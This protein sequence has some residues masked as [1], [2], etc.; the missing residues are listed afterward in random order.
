VALLLAI[1]VNFIV[2]ANLNL[3]V[4]R[5]VLGFWFI[6]IFPAY[7]IF[8]TSAWRACSLS[9]RLGYSV[10]ALLLILMLTGFAMS[11]ALPLAGVKRPLDSG[12]ILIASDLINISLYALRRRYPGEVRLRIS[13]AELGKEEFRLLVAGTLTVVL[14]VLGAN[15]L[16]NGA[17]GS[18]T[19]VAFALAALIG[20]FS[21]RWLSATRE[22]VMLVVIY[23]VGLSLLLTTSLRGWYVTGHDIQQE[24][25][26]FQLTEARGLWSMANDSG[27]YN[28]CLSI[29]ILPTEL[30]RMINI[31]NPYVYK[32]FFQTIFA[33]APVLAYGVAR[34]YFNRGIST[35]A[36]AYFIGFPTYFTDMPFLN[37]QEISLLFV[38]VG[39]LAATN[40]GWS[41][42]RRQ[43]ALVVAGLG[44][45]LSHYSTMYVFV[46]TLGIALVCSWAIGL[47]VKPQS[48]PARVRSRPRHRRRASGLR[49]AVTISLVGGFAGIIFLWGTLATNTTGQ[50]L[51][52]GGGAISSGAISLSV[53]GSQQVTPNEAMQ[54]LRQ[55]SLKS[56]G[57]QESMYLPASA[58]AK[59]PTPVVD[60]EQLSP[61]TT[62]GSAANSVGVPVATLN[63][64]ARN[65]VAYGEQLF[66]GIGLVRLVISRRRGQHLI[67]RQFF[68]LC[69]GSIGMIAANTVL[70]SIAA[71]YGPL[72]A[73]QQG[74]LFFSPIIVIGSMTV[75]EWLGR[76][77]AR[78]A[79]C[80]VCLG[81]FLATSTLVPQ[82]L[83]GN[84]AELNLNNSGL[85]YDL[86]YMIPQDSSAVAWLGTQPGAHTDPIQASF[87][88]EKF[89]FNSP[90]D[91]DGKEIILDDYPTL[92]LRNSWVILAPPTIGGDDAYTFTPSN[93]ALTEYKYPTD[94]LREFKNVVYTNGT[95]VIY[96]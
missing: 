82:I 10:C 72:R 68:C 26:V 74:L 9:E 55:D 69:I 41:W 42:R 18:V 60:D 88:Q 75:F 24:Y 37:R 64:F 39:V 20:I 35:L 6:L 76:Q 51:D 66:L 23:L 95:T 81:I 59:A 85:Y 11:E 70:P 31:D 63:A 71:D 12:P 8:A 1:V 47:F 52:A 7:L 45:E 4:V 14:A 78:L 16:N 91:V 62:L 53:F 89:F 93:G 86:Y 77:R 49:N 21:V 50:V 43:V 13:F 2:L 48:D 92:I 38:A 3:P 36:V 61:L 54:E 44:V 32:F 40:V 65:F 22:P 19:L 83:G 90:N 34:R 29:T 80:A 58:M 79:S 17:S 30:G 5:P 25:Q 84:L 46:G 28:A 33:L 87:L 67:G 73:F 15:R 57:S 94:I 96:K 56:R 27:A